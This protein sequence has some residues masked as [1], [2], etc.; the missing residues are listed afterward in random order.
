[1][2]DVINLKN[3][4][5]TETLFAE[6]EIPLTHFGVKDD[7]DCSGEF[8]ETSEIKE[9]ENK[10]VNDMKAN[11]KELN[12]LTEEQKINKLDALREINLEEVKSLVNTAKTN[13]SKKTS[14]LIIDLT[15]RLPKEIFENDKND[16]RTDS[17]YENRKLNYIDCNTNTL[18]CENDINNQNEMKVQNKI[19]SNNF[20]NYNKKSN[21]KNNKNNRDTNS[22]SSTDAHTFDKLSSLTMNTIN[23]IFLTTSTIPIKPINNSTIINSV[24]TT[25]TKRNQSKACI[26]CNTTVDG[27][28]C[29]YLICINCKLEF[30]SQIRGLLKTANLS[31][32]HNYEAVLC[33]S[34][35]VFCSNSISVCEYCLLSDFK[36][37][38]TPCINN[39]SR[40]CHLDC[41]SVFSMVTKNNNDFNYHASFIDR[42]Y[43][44][45][46]KEHCCSESKIV[47]AKESMRYCHLIHS[48]K[49]NRLKLLH[50]LS[51]YKLY[52]TIIKCFKYLSIISI[53]KTM[54]FECVECT[55]IKQNTNKIHLEEKNNS[56]GYLALTEIFMKVYD[57]YLNMLYSMT[58]K[59]SKTY[60]CLKK[61]TKP[62]LKKIQTNQ[63]SNP[64][65]KY[66]LKQ[67]NFFNSLP[68]TL[69]S[70]DLAKLT[71][72]YVY[73]ETNIRINNSR[74]PINSNKLNN[75]IDANDPNNFLP[76]QQPLVKSTFS[77][78]SSK[79]AQTSLTTMTSELDYCNCFD[80]LV[81]D[82][83]T[84]KNIKGS[85]KR[86]DFEITV[87]LLNFLSEK[88]GV[89]GYQCSNL[90]ILIH[91]NE[92]NCRTPNVLKK[93]CKNRGFFC[94]SDKHND[95]QFEQDLP[96][97]V[98]QNTIRI[99]E[100]FENKFDLMVYTEDYLEIVNMRKK[101]YG[102]I[103]TRLISKG[104]FVIE[105][106]GEVIE[107]ERLKIRNKMIEKEK[108][109]QKEK[110]IN[111]DQYNSNRNRKI[112]QDMFDNDMNSYIMML[113]SN[114]LYVDGRYY[115]NKSRFIN[116]SCSPNCTVQVW[117]DLN[118]YR[119]YIFAGRD[120]LPGEELTYDYKFSFFNKKTRAKCYC[121]TKSCRGVF[122]N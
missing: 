25:Q 108:E 34:K 60:V 36:G 79:T 16:E 110:R 96:L 85:F 21:S 40:M 35:C 3:L 46:I 5:K 57:D 107:H 88:D 91:C 61:Q 54:I 90:D 112:K 120:I 83:Y 98:N 43:R 44:M 111:E 47:L 99:V 75:S 89:C 78:K 122:G 6:E 48:T 106:I 11:N 50:F 27:R 97:K 12:E 87:G 41:L 64:K 2:T 121:N 4:R 13:R 66:T 84:S 9:L 65:S 51:K 55:K 45:L 30:Y 49:Q 104:E 15:N 62:E 113:K 38:L 94:K 77:V 39:C 1:M 59:D 92:M 86:N 95:L 52:R 37:F 116:H 119:C 53:S 58:L 72:S 71:N 101:G 32:Y 70:F 118:D 105:Y 7:Q 103:T 14:I 82:Y 117:L 69:T 23:Q 26:V 42:I 8:L 93:F 29:F 63:N 31:F 102:V 100:L 18:N 19:N 67:L 22:F 24:F 109:K 73:I 76:L 56:K 114:K 80:N 115:G 81:R 10:G 33:F 68:K 28:C 17:M 20:N 74:I